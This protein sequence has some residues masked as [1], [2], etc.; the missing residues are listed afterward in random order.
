MKESL[1]IKTRLVYVKKKNPHG[2]PIIRTIVKKQRII[3]TP[4]AAD[5]SEVNIVNTPPQI[6]D[7]VS[8]PLPPPPQEP[9]KKIVPKPKHS[10]LILSFNARIRP[11]P[12]PAAHVG[13]TLKPK[14]ANMVSTS[15]SKP[16]PAAVV[17]PKPKPAN[18][19]ISK[20][21]LANVVVPKPKPDNVVVPKPK[22]VA[23]SPATILSQRPQ[24]PSPKVRNPN[25][26]Y[27]GTAYVICDIPGNTV[28]KY[29]CKKWTKNLYLKEVYYLKY[30]NS[31]GYDWCPKFIDCNYNELWVKME[32]CGEPIKRNTAPSDWVA[33]VTKII[34]DIKNEGLHHNDIK[35]VEVLVKN[36]KVYVIDFG[37]MSKGHN[38]WTCGG[39]FE[40]V[41]K[42]NHCYRD[43][44]LVN[45]VNKVLGVNP[46]LRS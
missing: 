40:N 22:P 35:P 7:E 46:R 17:V 19:V 33:Q 29:F 20:P 2:K 15:I 45:R 6:P 31:K 43:S 44:E 16:K 21:K 13:G 28:T 27:G 4:A 24:P 39:I 32:Y 10:P 18:V 1:N 38:D 26:R 25:M 3:E 14:P 30:F 23:V 37:W 34:T 12:K 42:G 41:P 36:G 8:V 11:K 5:V 9:I